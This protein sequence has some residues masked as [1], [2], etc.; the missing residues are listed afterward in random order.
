MGN[1]C[2][3]TIYSVYLR[4]KKY[5]DQNKSRYL[6]SKELLNK[7]KPIELSKEIRI[8]AGLFLTSI[9]KWYVSEQYINLMNDIKHNSNLNHGNKEGSDN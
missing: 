6:S 4:V 3:H 9:N 5:N 1:K 8:R 7:N 2:H